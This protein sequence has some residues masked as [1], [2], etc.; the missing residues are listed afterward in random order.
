M[1]W[2]PGSNNGQSGFGM[3]RGAMF[4]SS[5]NGPFG[6]RGFPLPVNLQMPTGTVARPYLGNAFGRRMGSRRM[7]S[8]VYELTPGGITTEAGWGF[9]D[10][11]R[12]FGRDNICGPFGYG[13]RRRSRSHKQRCLG[14]TKNGKRCKHHAQGKF[15]KHHKNQ[16]R[17]SRRRRRSRRST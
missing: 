1:V 5:M 2:I 8:T 7:G 17:V 13:R 11:S 6:M 15:C 14:K 4:P 9:Q 10:R 12:S 3:V 16:D